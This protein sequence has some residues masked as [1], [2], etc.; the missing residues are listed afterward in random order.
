MIVSRRLTRERYDMKWHS[1]AALKLYSPFQIN[2]M[3]ALLGICHFP[4]YHEQC[5]L[6]KNGKQRISYMEISRDEGTQVACTV[7]IPE[8]SIQFLIILL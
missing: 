4:S 1:P 5:R 8:S 6:K 3:K 2:R 7:S